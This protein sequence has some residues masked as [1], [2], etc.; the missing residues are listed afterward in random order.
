MTVL[1]RRPPAGHQILPHPPGP[2]DR[3]VPRDGDCRPGIALDWQP[4]DVGGAAPNPRFTPRTGD[5]RRDRTPLCRTDRDPPVVPPVP[6]RRRL[7]RR[8]AADE[9][10]DTLA[11]RS[12][13][14]DS[15]FWAPVP[16][17]PS[18]SSRR[19]MLRWAA[20]WGR[21]GSPPSPTR[22]T[23]RSGN[24]SICPSAAPAGLQR[25]SSARGRRRAAPLPCPRTHGT[26]C[27]AHRRVRHRQPGGARGN[28][29]GCPPRRAASLGGRRLRHAF[30]WLGQGQASSVAESA[31]QWIG[32][33]H[34]AGRWPMPSMPPAG[35]DDDGP[36]G[37]GTEGTALMATIP[38]LD[39]ARVRR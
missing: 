20:D 14:D 12:Q 23:I 16:T 24:R 4:S 33:A 34:R 10:G 36:D 2:S 32:S 22:S 15:P 3:F 27:P 35:E 38:A 21:S 7:G 18:A 13:P 29:P 28:R 31:R 37:E 26:R 11:L 39:D 9:P 1:A 5:A 17:H 30:E 6:A 19:S 25:P 8:D